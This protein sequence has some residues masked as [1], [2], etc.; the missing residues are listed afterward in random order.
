MKCEMCGKIDCPCGERAANTGKLLLRLSLGS[1]FLY[2]GYAKVF[3]L[4]VGAFVGFLT[5]LN[6]P[7]PTIMA[8]IAAYGEIAVGIS[9]ILGIFTRWLSI[10]GLIISLVAMFSVHFK[11]GFDIQKGGYEYI[12]LIAA[13]FIAII[14][15]GSG[16]YA[17]DKFF[18]KKETEKSNL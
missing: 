8:H 5:S 13:S 15:V 12:Q 1:I 6:F 2:H 11:N 14:L 16:K 3:I 10:L 7:F 4:G 9:L 18:C 17:L